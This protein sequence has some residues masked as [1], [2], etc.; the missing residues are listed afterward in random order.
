MEPL[1][2]CDANKHS[3]VCLVWRDN[4]ATEAECFLCLTV[5]LWTNSVIKLSLCQELL[6]LEMSFEHCNLFK[7]AA[8]KYYEVV[9]LFFHLI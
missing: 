8:L 6:N 2:G 3:S 4:A 9:D 7:L 1:C 5:R